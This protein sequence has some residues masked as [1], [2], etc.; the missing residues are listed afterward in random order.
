MREFFQHFTFAEPAWLFLLLALPPLFFLRNRIGAGAGVGFPSLAILYS[1]GRPP[2]ERPGAFTFCL[3]GL[4]LA[5]AILALARPQW[6]N[7]FTVRTASGIDI[8]IAL[9]VSRSMDI[10]DFYPRDDRRR[11]E[12]RLDAAREVIENFV[13]R[14]PD[15]RIG[16]IVF[17][18]RPYSLSPITLNHDWVIDNLRRFSLGDIDPGGTAIGSAIAASATRLTQREAK[19]KIVVLVTDGANNSGKLKPVP[20][21]RLAATLGIRVYTVAIGTEEGR[22]PAS[23]MSNPRQEFDLPTLRTIARLT[24]AEYFRARTTRG[25]RDTFAGID[26]LEKTEARHH[27]VVESRDLYQWLVGASFLL[28]FLSLG[29]R[30]LDPPPLP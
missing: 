21:A 8:L 25:L 26:A 17:A 16:M 9:D 5:A 19:S 11:R 12:R 7:H 30:T 6:R 28:S 14:R 18:A 22:L 15:D 13:R 27:H 2:R 29:L 23:V 1:L 20:A 10:R 4:A 24:E 3:L